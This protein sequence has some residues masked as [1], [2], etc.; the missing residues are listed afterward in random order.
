MLYTDGQ[1]DKYDM[2]FP[3]PI[4]EEHTDEFYTLKNSYC[5][6][7]L[8]EFYNATKNGTEDIKLEKNAM[9]GREEYTIKV[10]GNGIVLCASCE[11]GFFRALT[12][13]RQLIRRESDKRCQYT[14]VHDKPAFEKRGFMLD[15]SRKRKPKVDYICEM[16]DFM[17]GMKYNEFQLY[18]EDFCFKYSEFPEYTEDLDV[19]T[20]EDIIRIDKFC[21]ERFVE[22]VPHQNGLGHMSTWLAQPELRHLAVGSTEV[23]PLNIEAN[24]G[25]INPL[26]P[27]SFEVVNKIYKSLLPHFSSKRVHIGLDEALALGTHQTK[28]ACDKYGV[29]KVFIDW[30]K[31]L[32]DLCEKEYGKSVMF[33]SDMLRTY[34]EAY[35]DIPKNAVPVAWGYEDMANQLRERELYNLKAN[36][37]EKFYV[38]PATQTYD[39]FTG[40][41]DSADMNL[42]MWAEIGQDYGAYGYL[43]SHWA[44]PMGIS[45]TVWAY[46]AT[47]LGAQYAWNPGIRQQGGW[48]K[49]HFRRNAQRYCD[50]YVFGGAKISAYM[51]EIMNSYL[52]APERIHGGEQVRAAMI[53][54]LDSTVVP[55]FF[56]FKNGFAFAYEEI[57]D[58]VNYYMEKIKSEDFDDT[59]KRELIV[60]CEMEI[61]GCDLA[62]Y[63]ITGE[64]SKELAEKLV[65]KLDW[66]IAEHTDLWLTRNYRVGM[67]VYVN[68]MKAR[69]NEIEN[70]IRK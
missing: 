14:E 16:I 6:E 52:L 57:K 44:N 56:D 36:N 66:I 13:V 65:D 29:A 26:D 39:C 15:I 48:R 27:E 31:K 61:V 55:N 35:P 2:I 58:R 12:S 59:Y 50:E 38:T 4:K 18:M 10:D 20:P 43:V 60:N 54:P 32:T 51:R 1:Q 42:R 17:A 7:D 30:L 47:A 49:Q 22:L 23:D 28:E 19:L 21:T 63:K 41:F 34:P 64:M 24:S 40:R 45:N 69:R 33:W 70:F 5:T 3:M 46:P 25:T 11:E 53:M 68:A 8:I 37:I 62:I 9:L 67:E